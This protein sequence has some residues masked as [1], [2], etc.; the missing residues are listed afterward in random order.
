MASR[1]RTIIFRRYR[2]ALKSVRVPASSSPASS[3]TTSAGGPVIELVSTS[4]INP[5]RS[6]APLSTEDPGNSSKGALTVG[7]PP[8]W[9]DV[10]EEIATNVQRARTRMAELAKAHAKALMPSFGDGKEDQRLIESLSQ[11][12][13]GL[14]KRSEKK[15]QRLSA[16]GPSEDSNVRKNVQRSLATDLQ[17]LS[18]ELRKKQSTYLKRLRQQKEG[19][20]GVDLE[21]NLN[22]NR[23]KMEDDDLDNMVFNEHQMAKLKKSEAFT[24][25]REREIQQVVESVNELAQIMKDLSVLVIDQGT[26]VDRIDYNIQN[27]ATTVEEGL[28]QLQ[29]AERT[30]KH[31]GM[32][33]CATVLIIM[34]F[35]MLVLLILKEI[36]L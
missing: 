31:G 19:Q 28:K 18:M 23:S 6:Y 30:Q 3:S 32:V 25:E 1:N 26:I 9:V 4:L 33:R 34:C 36:F 22:G 27:V 24:A 17:N 5:N 7:L 21:M 29:K 16:A 2:D 20:D 12:I 8:A 10:S 35:I 15:L 13:T 11:E 14:I